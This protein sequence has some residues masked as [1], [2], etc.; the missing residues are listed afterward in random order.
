M[1]IL[2]SS[3]PRRAQI[4]TELGIRFE[5]DPV[6]MSEDILPGEAPDAAASRLADAKAALAAHRHPSDWIL[7]ADTLVFLEG[8]ILGKPASDAEAAAMLRRLSGR[9]HRVVTGVRLRRGTAP[10]S[11]AVAWSGVSFATLSEEEIAWYVAT[12]E[13]RDKAGAY[14]VQGKGARFIEKIEGSYTNVM[15]LPA[16][17]IYRIMRA[18]GDPALGSLALSSR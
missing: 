2:A 3:S 13:P 7:A 16:R 14:G 11:G 6:G 10:G 1:L 9:T 8:E 18:A 4:L 15:G 12:G 5:I 17:D